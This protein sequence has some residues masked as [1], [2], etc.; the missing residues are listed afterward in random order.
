[1]IRGLVRDSDFSGATY[2]LAYGEAC[3]FAR[4]TFHGGTVWTYNNTHFRACIFDGTGIAAYVTSAQNPVDTVPFTVLHST[5]Y[6][7]W[8]C[9]NLGT[10]QHGRFGGIVRNCIFSYINNYVFYNVQ[11]GYGMVDFDHNCYFGCAHIGQLDGVDYHS[12]AAWRATV[13]ADGVSPDAHS[14]DSDPLLTDPAADD[15]SLQ[16]ASPCRHRGSGAGVVTGINGVAFDPY[17]CDI[18]AWSSGI[19]PNRSN[20]S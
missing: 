2:I 15:F 1:M 6:G 17:H 19:G 10:S 11:T 7:V 14:I 13:D 18:G 8:I 4:C 5:F 16:A 20:S 12:L 9:F 3:T